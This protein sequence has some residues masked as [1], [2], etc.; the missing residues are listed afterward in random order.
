VTVNPADHD[1]QAGEASA[2]AVVTDLI[3]GICDI[4]EE[5]LAPSRCIGDLG[6]DS[7]LAG[8]IMAQAELALKIDIDFSRIRD[9]WS[10]LT[11]AELAAELWRASSGDGH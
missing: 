6:I 4:D 7:I 11:L 10:D 1:Q 9:D 8:E 2:L 3:S 5:E